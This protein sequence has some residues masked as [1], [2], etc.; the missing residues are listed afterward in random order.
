MQVIL[1]VIT[2]LLPRKPAKFVEMQRFQDIK[3]MEL[4][5]QY[6][7]PAECSFQE[8]LTPGEIAEVADTKSVFLLE[9]LMVKK[10]ENSHRGKTMLPLRGY[11]LIQKD[12]G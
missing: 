4:L 11:Y 3:S 6:A 12:K 1:L 8:L 7:M 2:S 10:K 5:Q 9:C